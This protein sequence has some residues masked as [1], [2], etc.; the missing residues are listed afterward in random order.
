MTLIRCK[1]GPT[2]QSVHN[3]TWKFAIDR[4]GR[5][6]CDVTDEKA[7]AMF[8]AREDVYEL[9]DKLPE[10][11]PVRTIMHQLGDA[12]FEAI[13]REDAE[14]ANA[15]MQ[16]AKPPAPK[17]P[18]AAEVAAASKAAQNRDKVAAETAASII[19]D[20]TKKPDQA[21]T[22]NSAPAGTV[23]TSGLAAAIAETERV[24]QEP[25]PASDVDPLN[26]FPMNP[27]DTTGP[28]IGDDIPA[29]AATAPVPAAPAKPAKKKRSL[30]RR[31]KST[32]RL[33]G[34]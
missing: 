13:E 28:A 26:Q 20:D 22:D 23:Q 25:A 24:P 30:P 9:A 2:E 7:E 31:N 34:K 19:A 18:T 27:G 32:G 11:K 6:I 33:A 3:T 1:I 10:V 8:L 29:T 15:S 17:K 12:D 4:D 16:T 21:S 5:A 14:R